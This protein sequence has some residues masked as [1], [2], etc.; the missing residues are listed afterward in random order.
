[1]VISTLVISSQRPTPTDRIESS[2]P[3]SGRM[4]PYLFLEFYKS[5]SLN[6]FNSQIIDT[7][8]VLYYN[9]FYISVRDSCRFSSVCSCFILTIL[10]RVCTA[11][12]ATLIVNSHYHEQITNISTRTKFIQPARVRNIFFLQKS[13]TRFIEHARKA[14]YTAVIFFSR[15]SGLC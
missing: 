2:V 14:T 11:L 15:V 6:F 10:F 5:L 3:R 12:M 13:G 4:L 7:Y 9:V 1:M 8:R